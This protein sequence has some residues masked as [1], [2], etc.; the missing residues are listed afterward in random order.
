MLKLLNPNI[1]SELKAYCQKWLCHLSQNDFDQA[2]NLVTVPNNY[3]TRWGKKEIRDAVFDYYG[4]ESKFKIENT[5]IA[6]CTP[7]FEFFRV[8]NNEFSAT[9]NDIHVL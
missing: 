5:D 2:L 7:E 8:N 9:I 1:E 3:G 4:S 6:F